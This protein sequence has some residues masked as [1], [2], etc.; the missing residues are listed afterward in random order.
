STVSFTVAGIAHRADITANQTWHAADNPHFV[1]RAI[2]VGPGAVTLTLEPGTQVRFSVAAGLVFDGAQATLKAMGT[3]ASPISLTADSAAV[4]QANPIKGF[5]SGV[6]LSSSQS[7]LH[8]VVMSDIVQLRLRAALC[9]NERLRPGHLSGDPLLRRLPRPRRPLPSGSAP[10]TAKR[11]DQG[12]RHH[13][14]PGPRRRRLGPRLGEP[15]DHRRWSVLLRGWWSADLHQRER[16][17]HHP[18]DDHAERQPR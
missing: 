11:H 9:R 4:N 18:R 1:R 3:S 6:L 7:E 14:T 10:A 15:R 13:R 2:H 16:S 8:Y 17:R 12:L 5:W